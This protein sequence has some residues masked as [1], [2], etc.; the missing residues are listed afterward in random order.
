M[1]DNEFVLKNV[2]Q[3]LRLFLEYRRK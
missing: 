3:T 2:R 1:S